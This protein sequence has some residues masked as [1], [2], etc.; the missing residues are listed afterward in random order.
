MRIT[1]TDRGQGEVIRQRS[2]S[3]GAGIV[4]LCPKCGLTFTFARRT[5]PHDLVCPEC[6]TRLVRRQK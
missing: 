4:Y 1:M 6:G 3:T 2:R 5:A